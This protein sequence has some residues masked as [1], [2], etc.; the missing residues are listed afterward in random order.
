M[1]KRLIIIAPIIA[2]IICAITP[3]T[4]LAYTTPNA[5]IMYAIA[6]E[7]GWDASNAVALH[8]NEGEYWLMR[9][10][11][12]TYSYDS[13]SNKLHAQITYSLGNVQIMKFDSRNPYSKHTEANWDMNN[14]DTGDQVINCTVL[15]TKTTIYKWDSAKNTANKNEVFMKAGSASA[16]QPTDPI[17]PETPGTQHLKV[18]S[19]ITSKQ[20]SGVMSEL[21]ATLPTVLPVLVTFLAIRKA[22]AFTLATLRSA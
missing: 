3:F 13:S 15:G 1:K 4:A 12:A 18:S 20:L 11:R 22:I 10:S 14:V 8:T 6:A 9:L 17:N 21:V 5:D 16:T 7:E 2:V 19:S